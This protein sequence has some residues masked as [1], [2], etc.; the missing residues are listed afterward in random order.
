MENGTGTFKPTRFRILA[1]LDGFPVQVTC[2]GKS[3]V[4]KATVSKLK[5]LG[6]VA[7]PVPTL[8]PGIVAPLAT[9]DDAPPECPVH[10][11]PMKESRKRGQWFC[12]KKDRSGYC[13]ESVKR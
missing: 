4:L 5:E 8:S 9:D 13:D 11:T 10:G 12:P 2:Y 6:A 3:D 7:P 1:E